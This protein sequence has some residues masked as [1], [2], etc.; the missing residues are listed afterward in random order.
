MAPIQFGNTTNTTVLKT[1]ISDFITKTGNAEHTNLIIQDGK[2]LVWRIYFKLVSKNKTTV[3][4]GYDVNLKSLH[5]IFQPSMKMRLIMLL[6][7][8][9]MVF[10]SFIPMQNFWGKIFLRP[11]ICRLLILFLALKKTFLKELHSPNT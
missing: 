4:Y 3:R 7:L 5:V 1:K 11:Q 9:K 6:S 2:E 8:I 10:V